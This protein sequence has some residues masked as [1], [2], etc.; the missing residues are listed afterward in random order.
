MCLWNFFGKL[1]GLAEHPECKCKGAKNSDDFLDEETFALVTFLGFD[2]IFKCRFCGEM[3]HVDTWEPHTAIITIASADD[4]RRLEQ[5]ARLADEQQSSS[6]DAAS[7]EDAL[8]LP[9]RSSASD[10][11]EGGLSEPGRE[12]Q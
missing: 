9:D 3:Y 8:I 4:V 10:I 2:A 12:Q 1:L 5:R 6:G 11:S 7:H